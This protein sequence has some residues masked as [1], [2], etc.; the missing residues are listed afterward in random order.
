MAIKA[1][2]YE[3]ALK[4]FIIGVLSAAILLFGMSLVYGV[5]GE[6]TFGAIRA[7]TAALGVH[8]GPGAWALAYQIE[9]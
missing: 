3:A 7:A 9:D 4:Y 5:T 8:V 6:V 2:D 1:L